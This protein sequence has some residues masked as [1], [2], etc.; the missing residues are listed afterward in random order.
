MFQLIGYSEQKEVLKINPKG[1]DY[2]SNIKKAV[3]R[4][5]AIGFSILIVYIFTYH[6]EE[7]IAILQKF[8]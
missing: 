3:G 2:I 7:V 4:I 6:S 5:G 1:G 8:F